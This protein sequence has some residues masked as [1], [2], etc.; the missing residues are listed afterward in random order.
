MALDNLRAEVLGKESLDACHPPGERGPWTVDGLRYRMRARRAAQGSV[1]A[2][3]RAALK[4]AAEF[5]QNDEARDLLGL[6]RIRV[7]GE[8]MTRGGVAD[9]LQIELTRSAAQPA[10]H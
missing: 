5:L 10:Q 3:T 7:N 4:A 2:T 8:M 6:H 1:P 9:L